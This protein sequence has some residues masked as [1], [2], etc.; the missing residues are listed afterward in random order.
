VLDNN[1]RHY[2]WVQRSTRALR[3]STAHYLVVS[4]ISAYDLP[5]LSYDKA[6]HDRQQPLG[7]SHRLFEPPAGWDEA[8][9]VLAPGNPNHSAQVIDQRNL[10]EWIVRLAESETTGD[11]LA[12]GSATRLTTREMLAACRAVTS[13]AVQLTWVSESFL[14]EQKV[15]IW[16]ERR[17]CRVR[18]SG[19]CWRYGTRAG[20]RGRLRAVRSD[21]ARSHAPL[22][23]PGPSHTHSSSR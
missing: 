1:A 21:G 6:G 3:D 15:R 12:I 11:F 23:E 19:S 5:R 16:S 17:G 4:S 7:E 9:E 18:A 10:T 8:G 14:A 20:G 2:R 13:S 22:V